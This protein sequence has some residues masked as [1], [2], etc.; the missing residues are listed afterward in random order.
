QLLGR[1]GMGDVYLAEDSRLARKV[2][3]KILPAAVS[4]HPDRL[5]RF[6]REAR[7]V[8]ALN[9][10]NIITIFEVG[11]ADGVRFLA[12]E[13]VE[14]LRL[15]QMISRKRLPPGQVVELAD[16]ITTALAAAHSAG[17]V[18]RD[19]KPENIMVR[20]DSLVKVLDF[21][22]AKLAGPWPETAPSS[23]SLPGI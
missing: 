19:I 22:L 10:P 4:K 5:L 17:I 2:A 3:L 13:Y 7:A 23:I 6:E 11:E 9:H 8:S 20:R 16:Q 1:G 18:H 21:G 12:M 15:R 14:G